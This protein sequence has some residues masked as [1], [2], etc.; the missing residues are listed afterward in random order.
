MK[1]LVAINLDAHAEIVLAQAVRWATAMSAT[2]DVVYVDEYNY[3]G[4]IIRDP[5]V[6]KIVLDQWEKLKASNSHALE[7]LFN[8]VPAE[9][10]GTL[11]HRNGR[12]AEEIVLQAESG[13]DAVLIATHGRTGLPHL[14]LGS[15]AEKV[16]RQAPCAVVVLRLPAKE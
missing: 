9:V 11:F 7:E 8:A 10:R 3:N 15:V 2:L 5:A 14:F 4:A 16:M 1:T 6:R 13:Y 12:A